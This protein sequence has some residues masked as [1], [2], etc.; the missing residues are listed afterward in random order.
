MQCGIDISTKVVVELFGLLAEILRQKL[1][2]SY[3]GTS[4]MT[5]RKKEA[6]HT[7]HLKRKEQKVR[8]VWSS[9]GWRC[10]TLF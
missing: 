9:I 7:L 5:C 10:N 6:R 4:V 2:R 8:L 1:K 3:A